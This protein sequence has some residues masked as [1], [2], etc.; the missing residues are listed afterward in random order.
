ML[1]PREAR[2]LHLLLCT[3]KKVKGEKSGRL[4]EFRTACRQIGFQGWGRAPR[5]PPRGI[6]ALCACVRVFYVHVTAVFVLCGVFFFSLFFFW[7][8]P[9]TPP[10]ARVV[11]ASALAAFGT[12]F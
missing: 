5:T 11:T 9:R 4:G 10:C 2:A 8:H 7:P 3:A 6:G 12:F 1:R